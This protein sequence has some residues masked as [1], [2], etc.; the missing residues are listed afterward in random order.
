VPSPSLNIFTS[1]NRRYEDFAPLF[2]ASCLISNPEATVEILL[3]DVD[4]FMREHY[5]A[6]QPVLDG[7][8][9]GRILLG[10]APFRGPDG[11]DIVPNSVR[12]LTA[13]RLRSDY[14][15]ISDIDMITLDPDIFW[16]HYRHMLA[17]RLPFSNLVSGGGQR[18]SGLHF[19]RYDAF[20]PIPD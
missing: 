4:R 3:E 9:P 11:R 16:K 15:Y 5:R 20:Y 6:M 2:A 8:L 17:T 19:T 10:E 12:F 13:P 7:A 1:A 18:L 14:V